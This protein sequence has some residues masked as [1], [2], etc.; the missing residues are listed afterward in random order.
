M[1]MDLEVKE[2]QKLELEGKREKRRKTVKTVSC[3]GCLVLETE[4]NGGV[5]QWKRC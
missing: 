5:V 2:E 4:I 3:T 1:A